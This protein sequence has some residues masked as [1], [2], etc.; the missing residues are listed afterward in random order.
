MQHGPGRLGG[1]AGVS[2]LQAELAPLEDL[3]VT[4]QLLNLIRLIKLSS[5]PDMAVCLHALKC[6]QYR[7]RQ[8]ISVLYFSGSGQ[9]NIV[10]SKIYLR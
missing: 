7:C 4:L 1:S 9:K 2:S 3:A 6:D 8:T 5:L 10:C